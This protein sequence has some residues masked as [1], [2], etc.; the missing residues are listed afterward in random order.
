MQFETD[1]FH[2]LC[3]E[4]GIIKNENVD[5]KT[6]PANVWV[7]KGHPLSHRGPPWGLR[8]HKFILKNLALKIM[9]IYVF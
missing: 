4:K 6:I 5:K 3:E 8:C 7:D 9:K 1:F 2:G